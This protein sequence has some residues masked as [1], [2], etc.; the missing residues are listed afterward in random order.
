MTLPYSKPTQA[1]SGMT[2][3]DS[4]DQVQ[5]NDGVV[6]V[7]PDKDNNQFKLGNKQITIDTTFEPYKHAI[8]T[9]TVVKVPLRSGDQRTSV[10]VQHG[11]RVFFHYLAMSNAAKNNSCVICGDEYLMKINYGSM[12]VAMREKE[13]VMLNGYILVVPAANDFPMR[14][15]GSIKIPQHL[16]DAKSAFKGEVRHVGTPLA[17][18]ED[19]LNPG[20][21]VY[22]RKHSDV[23]LQYEL[24]RDFKE[25]EIFWR[26]K[27]YNVLAVL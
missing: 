14:L 10:E 9:G 21:N 7:K 6:L 22:F 26:M 1:K 15:P 18:E 11:D 16:M 19:F 8:T 3:V 17:G 27:R 20:D 13:V 4:F 24:H 25:K 12:F 5:A 2:E 23:P